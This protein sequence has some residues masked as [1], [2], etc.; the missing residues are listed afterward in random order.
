[1]L[2]FSWPWKSVTKKVRIFFNKQPF[3]TIFSLQS[4]HHLYL[5]YIFVFRLVS[6][7]CCINLIIICTGS[8]LFRG[9]ATLLGKKSPFSAED[10]H[11]CKMVTLPIDNFTAQLH[12]VFM[13][14]FRWNFICCTGFCFNSVLGKIL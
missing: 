13:N 9:T 4:K 2:F 5:F 7:K 6:Q 10:Y 8:S 11:N 12:R 14:F 1:M 3:I